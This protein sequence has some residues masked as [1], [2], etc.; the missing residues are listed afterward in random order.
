MVDAG[1]TGWKD[2]DL[3]AGRLEQ[4]RRKLALQLEAFALAGI[5]AWTPGEGDLRLGPDTVQELV[6]RHAIPAISSNL[7]C[8][9]LTL[10]AHREV[11]RDG[12]K[13]GFVAIID[14]ALLP[15]EAGCT[16][17]PPLPALVE[18]VGALP[19]DLD[20]VVLLSHQ[21]VDGDAALAAAVPRL[22]FV[23]NGHSGK[24]LQSPAA[25]GDDA[26]QLAA[27][28][29]GKA[30]GLAR[31][32]FTPGASGYAASAAG[33]E[34]LE[35]RIARYADR[36]AKA[37]ALLA[38][39]TTDAPTRSRAERQKAFYAT[40]LE[41]MK[42]RLEEAQRAGKEPR[43]A[44]EGELV[45]LGAEVPDHGPTAQLVQAALVGLEEAERAAPPEA[46]HS[47]PPSVYT[48]SAA[49]AECHPSQHGQWSTTAHA[50]AFQ[51]LQAERRHLDLSCYQ[52]HVTG[53]F[54]ERGPRHPVLVEQAL[55]EVGCES[56]HGPGRE[57]AALAQ[58]GEAE[59]SRAEVVRDPPQET[60]VLC[61]DGEQDEGRF[62]WDTYRPKVVHQ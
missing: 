28:N 59:A 40:E 35:R 1:D 30:L 18:A 33:V 5:D 55:Q 48:G 45:Q 46:T 52:C 50:R 53:A 38:D 57:H 44:V 17:E 62:D 31:I 43:H 20:A 14:P 9:G 37:D 49:C 34:E 39:P 16:A 19:A 2:A 61:H 8:P 60:C 10:P 6:T 36:A 26:I 47:A 42:A 4:H 7:R 12:V 3:T 58:A 22:D 54:D 29:R 32:R 25:L 56:C 23:V 11:E 27:G 15:P 51:T 21:G 41:Q 24:L 13:L